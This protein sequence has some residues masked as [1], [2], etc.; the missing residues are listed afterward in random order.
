VSCFAPGIPRRAQCSVARFVF[1]IPPDSGTAAFELSQSRKCRR[2]YAAR[3][4]GSCLS[5]HGQRGKITL[6]YISACA[7]QLECT[8][9]CT[10]GIFKNKIYNE[11]SMLKVYM[12]E[13][14]GFEPSIGLYNPIT[15]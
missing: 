15:V 4:A 2:G 8:L 14:E 5:I 11:I 1:K 13:T 10:L 6:L 3:H 7:G 12:A 9:K